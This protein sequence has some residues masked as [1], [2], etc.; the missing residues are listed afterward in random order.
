MKEFKSRYHN[1]Y[2]EF[3]AKER[4]SINHSGHIRVW[5]ILGFGT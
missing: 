1:G 5:R 4:K 2:R 3:R